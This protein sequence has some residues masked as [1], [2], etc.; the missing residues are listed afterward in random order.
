MGKLKNVVELECL[1][2]VC[3]SKEEVELL[4]SL[5]K[6][7]ENT[8]QITG[9]VTKHHAELMTTVANRERG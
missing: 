5:L 6:L 1:V 4:A 3:T 7:R 9:I 8:A 2:M